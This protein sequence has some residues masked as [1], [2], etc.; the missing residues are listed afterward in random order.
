MYQRPGVQV[1]MHR[2]RKRNHPPSF[3]I[4]YPFLN[5]MGIPV[6][7]RNLKALSSVCCPQGRVSEN[8][9]NFIYF[10]CFFTEIQGMETVL[11]ISI[12]MN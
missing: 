5:I 1:E 10:T 9:F 11:Q 8:V 3:H 6:Y 12:L 2:K 7:S 4:L